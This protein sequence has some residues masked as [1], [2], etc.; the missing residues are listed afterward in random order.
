MRPQTLTTIDASGGATFSATTPLDYVQAPFAVGF[1][2]VVTGSVNFTV[3][4]TFD[5]T[6]WFDHSSVA[7][8]TA[9]TDGNYAFP[10][11]QVRLKQSSGS[12]SCSMTLIQGRR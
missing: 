1:G 11:L 6:N 7:A 5:G 8:K 10:V 9:N 3:Q 12:G 2:V 4:H